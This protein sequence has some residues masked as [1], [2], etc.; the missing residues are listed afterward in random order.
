MRSRYCRFTLLHVGRCVVQHYIMSQRPPPLPPLFA[1]CTERQAI[2]AVWYFG[3]FHIC[4]TF[5]SV[6][7]SGRH[8]YVRA[9]GRGG[10]EITFWSARQFVY[11]EVLLIFYKVMKTV[12]A[13]GGNFA[14]LK[15]FF[16][17]LSRVPLPLLLLFSV[18]LLLFFSCHNEYL[19]GRFQF[20][21]DV[22][23]KRLKERW[24]GRPFLLDSGGRG[25]DLFFQRTQ[26]TSQPKLSY[27]F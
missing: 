9:W 21:R 20:F 23:R 2:R 26:R 1:K 24:S 7:Y 11:C 14:V 3:V 6:R 25:P 17:S 27:W 22:N 5:W 15:V 12:L 10:H 19:E 16:F 13:D 8:F 18:F 4:L